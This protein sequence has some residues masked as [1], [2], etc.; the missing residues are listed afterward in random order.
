M[1]NLS[2]S[3]SEVSQGKIPSTTRYDISQQQFTKIDS[4]ITRRESEKRLLEQEQKFGR[5][6][7]RIVELRNAGKDARIAAQVLDLTQFEKETDKNNFRAGFVENGNRII[8]G[9]IEKLSFDELEA[10]GKNDYES[11]LDLS[12][13][14]DIIK[15]NPAYTQGYMMASIMGVSKG[16]KGR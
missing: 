7:Y 4:E 6:S 15:E 16:K 11:G 2:Q 8:M 1:S 10:Y 9:N 13:I 3:P 14:P 12:E 5:D